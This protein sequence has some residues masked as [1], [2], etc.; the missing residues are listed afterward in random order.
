[1][2]KTIKLSSI[3]N[4]QLDKLSDKRKLEQSLV[5]TKQALV[6]EAVE[7]LYRKEIKRKAS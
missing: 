5:K 7:L 6:A 2:S 4:E 1:M 3:T